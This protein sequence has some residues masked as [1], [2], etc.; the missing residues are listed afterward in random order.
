L[1]RRTLFRNERRR[2]DI[3]TAK[4]NSDDN[5]KRNECCF[6]VVVV[7][8]LGTFGMN[9]GFDDEGA[10]FILKIKSFLKK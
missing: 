4:G 6:V 2:N 5:K 7:V 1:L 10:F 3:A 8:A 9:G